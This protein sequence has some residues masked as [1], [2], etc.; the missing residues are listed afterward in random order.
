MNYKICKWTF[1]VWMGVNDW[2]CVQNID[3]IVSVI[4]N[5]DLLCAG[6]GRRW[7]IWWRCWSRLC[8]TGMMTVTRRLIASDTNSLHPLEQQATQSSTAKVLIIISEH[9]CRKKYSGWG[10]LSRVSVGRG[11]NQCRF[12]DFIKYSNRWTSNSSYL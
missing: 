5:F 12:S 6:G 9:W 2:Q 10:K 3:G 11:Q 7:W 1:L 4:Y 8:T